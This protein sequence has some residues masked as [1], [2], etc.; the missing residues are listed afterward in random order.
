MRWLWTTQHVRYLHYNE[1]LITNHI[2]TGVSVELGILVV[3]ESGVIIVAAC[4]MCIWPLFTRILPRRLQA[5]F[6]RMPRE[7]QH[8]YWYLRDIRSNSKSDE[9]I[10]PCSEVH[11]PRD[12][13][14]N[15]SP[16]TPCSLA[17]LE[18][19]RLSILVDDTTEPRFN[20]IRACHLEGNI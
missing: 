18:D 19:Q 5:S 10:P 9:Q 3:L 1:A 8:Q 12:D 6:S 20:G 4:L 14:W 2:Q 16:S 15:S 13:A 11:T 7:S 17:D